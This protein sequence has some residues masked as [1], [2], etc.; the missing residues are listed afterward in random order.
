MSDLLNRPSPNL[1]RPSPNLKTPSFNTATPPSATRRGNYLLEFAAVLAALLPVVLGAIDINSALQGYSAVHESAETAARCLYP[2]DAG[3]TNASAFIDVHKFYD[4]YRDSNVTRFR[5]EKSDY[6]GKARWLTAP[7]YSWD[8]YAARVYTS[9][10]YQTPMTNYQRFAPGVE[11]RGDMQLTVETKPL[12][13]ASGSLNAPSFS[14]PGYNFPANPPGENRFIVGDN[15]ASGVTV[16]TNRVT[17]SE[18]NRWVDLEAALPTDWANSAWMKNLRCFKGASFGSASPDFTQGCLRD[19]ANSVRVAF[20]VNGRCNGSGSKHLTLSIRYQRA[21]SAT[22]QE[23]VG[24]ADN[25][26]TVG[27]GGQDCSNDVDGGFDPRGFLN[28]GGSIWNRTPSSVAALY[29]PADT[30]RVRVRVTADTGF[31]SGNSY[32]LYL[33]EFAGH[34][35]SL[36]FVPQYNQASIPAACTSCVENAV[37]CNPLGGGATFGDG[38]G[39]IGFVTSMNAAAASPGTRV[40][41]TNLVTTPHNN[42]DGPIQSFPTLTEATANMAGS[43]SY[44]CPYVIRD[45]GPGTPVT[46]TL[47]CPTNGQ[48]Q[49][50]GKREI[51][52][53]SI[54]NQVPPQYQNQLTFASQ[55]V[56]APQSNS[57]RAS[58]NWTFSWI[59][60]NC[61]T[62]YRAAN[63]VAPSGLVSGYDDYTAP[64]A[65]SSASSITYTD[66]AT[67]NGA[68]P[69]GPAGAPYACAE[70]QQRCA[71]YDVLPAGSQGSADCPLATPLPAT[72]SSSIFNGP[73]NRF[74]YNQE[75][76]TTALRQEAVGLGMAPFKYFE[77]LAADLVTSNDDSLY[78]SNCP[79]SNIVCASKAFIDGVVLVASNV[80]E[81]T[82]PPGCAAG[83]CYPRLSGVSAEGA[84]GVA[85][86][87]ATAASLGK[88][89]FAAAFS[90][91]RFDCPEGSTGPDCA[92]VSAAQIGDEVEVT[93]KLNVPFYFLGNNTRQMSHT[94]RRKL[95]RSYVR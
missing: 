86:E 47:N 10:S 76:L 53:Q 59:K 26:N 40:L 95:E 64:A 54:I 41:T 39:Q 23:A 91:A 19:S 36:F 81:G 71:L 22:W 50:Y 80:P 46:R 70:F 38:T 6:S 13:T 78:A 63:F 29:V 90:R 42:L 57:E 15:S 55:A 34:D 25:G 74:N 35:G 12:P 44:G 67:L 88:Q 83:V 94:Q 77:P 51:C 89:E 93:T 28:F 56:T 82:T 72:A 1:N 66:I 68:D 87:L 9:A 32:N 84:G 48:G 21:G 61:S 11:K 65:A 60:G 69:R 73:Q 49:Y 24:T 52:R 17:L 2:T 4:W 30:V 75:G 7:T 37:S 16:E 5:P 45:V 18:N 20:W 3:C 33:G 8:T 58:G 85:V 92:W 14:Y 27:L 79:G 31:T 62:Q 43:T